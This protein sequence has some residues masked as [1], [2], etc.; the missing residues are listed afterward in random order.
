MTVTEFMF[1]N[2]SRRGR[3]L[4]QPKEFSRQV[5]E[6]STTFLENLI[7]DGQVNDWDESDLLEVIGGFLKG[8]VRE[9]YIENR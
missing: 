2:R 5:G 1:S 4:V 3:P 7:V 8:D 9:W 6:D